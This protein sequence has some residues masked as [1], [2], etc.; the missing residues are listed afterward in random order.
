MKRMIRILSFALLLC[1]ML[2]SFAACKD[3]SNG[4]NDGEDDIPKEKISLVTNEK[5]DYV[6]VYN[7]KDSLASYL[8]DSLWSFFYDNF[9]ASISK[10]GDESTFDY[11]IVLCDANREEIAGLK[12]QMRDSSDFVIC[13]NGKRL[14]LYAENQ[15]GVKRLMITLRDVFLKN[16]PDGTLTV[17]KDLVYVGSQQPEESYRGGVATVFA[18]GKSDYTIICNVDSEEDQSL[19][20][21]LRRELSSK[22]KLDLEMGGRLTE[23]TAHEI[24]V[25]LS[26]VNRDAYK[27]ARTLLRDDDDF[28]VTVSDQ[29]VIITANNSPSLMMAIEFFVTNYVENGTC[30]I[31]EEDEYIDSMNNGFTVD[32]SRLEYLYR[33]VLGLYPTLR[34]E[35]LNSGVQVSDSSKKDQ[36]M[37]EVLIQQMGKSAVFC[38]GSSSVLYDGMI[39]KLD[40]TD[41]SRVASLSEGSATVPTEFVNSYLKTGYTDP[42]VDLKQAADAAGYTYYYD[43]ERQIAIVSPAGAYSFEN[44]SAKVGKYTNAKFKDRMV[45]FFNNPAM[46]EPNN[47]TEQSRV[48]IAGAENYYPEDALD[49]TQPSYTCNYSPSIVSVDVGNGKTLLYASYEECTV[50]NSGEP[51]AKTHVYQSTDG[52][53]TWVKKQTYDKLKWATLIE[54]GERVYIFGFVKPSATSWGGYCS[55]ADVTDGSKTNPLVK[56]FDG[57]SSV[58]EPLIDD[59]YLYLALNGGVASIDVTKD[60]LVASNWTKTPGPNEYVTKEWFEQIIGKKIGQWGMGTA[61]CQEGVMVKGRDGEIY[62]IYRVESQ[63]YGNYAVMMKLSDDRTTLEYLPNGGSVI[64]LPTTVSRFVIKY[65]EVSDKYVMISNLWLSGEI[66]NRARN[67]LGLSVS[68]DLENWTVVDTLLVDREMI[69]SDYSCYAHAYQYPDFDFDGDDIVLTVREATGFTNTFHDG[70]YFTFYRVTDFR[71]MFS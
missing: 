36:E 16:S 64:N 41:Y 21:F 5:T 28:V 33:E 55:I 54:V 18:D 71:S 61:E 65:D 11:E 57:S 10:R 3:S 23:E 6:L 32:R 19:A 38:N 31:A 66:G 7:Q 56:L 46:P 14:Y 48:E 70:K 24:V 59:G 68:D 53:K 62:V 4:A 12:A 13:Q 2:G 49:Y 52:G 20:Y 47:N 58:F 1:M 30:M 39:C 43:R 34:E 37:I 25:G 35:Y 51:A 50:K 67:V 45:A 15:T 60:L 9:K 44:D 29:K 17:E 27:K 42:T 40:K 26:T 63:P 8:A 22:T 69:N